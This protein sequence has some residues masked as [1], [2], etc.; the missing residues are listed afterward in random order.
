MGRRLRGRPDPKNR[1][2]RSNEADDGVRN[3]RGTIAMARTADPHSATAQF[4]I[5]TRDND[6]LN[7]SAP[8]H[9]GWGYCV[10]GQVVDGM[11]VVERI[12]GVPTGNH[13]G[14]QNVTMRDVV[15]N[16]MEET[17]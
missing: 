16:R 10:F 2:R 7:F 17:G 9:E 4:F 1:A 12:A 5:N 3:A 6:F 11:Q 14:P 8:T 15:I 13:G